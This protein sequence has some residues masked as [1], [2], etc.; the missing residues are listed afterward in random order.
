MKIICGHRLLITKSPVGQLLHVIRAIVQESS[1][2]YAVVQLVEQCDRVHL[3]LGVGVD[4]ITLICFWF[5]S[6]GL[7]ALG[8]LA[9]GLDSKGLCRSVLDYGHA[10]MTLKLLSMNR[11]LLQLH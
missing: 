1:F 11:R 6:I 9:F 4:G 2:D 7:L 10:I 8:L 5:C 3:V